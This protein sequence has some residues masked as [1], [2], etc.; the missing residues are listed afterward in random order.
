M[1]IHA[2]SHRPFVRDLDAT[3]LML[4]GV[5]F[6]FG[7]SPI[8]G[9]GGHVPQQFGPRTPSSS[10]QAAARAAALFFVRR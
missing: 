9:V 10:D 6:S 3:C 7:S 8:T 5:G 2:R 1:E 4:L